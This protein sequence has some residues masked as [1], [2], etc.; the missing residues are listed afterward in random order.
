MIW[1][2]EK[3][4]D[5][6]HCEIR[7]EMTGSGYELVIGG[8]E[9]EK[10]EKVESPTALIARSQDIWAGLLKGGWRPLP[11]QGQPPL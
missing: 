1:F 7:R 3:E 9:E 10:V 4:S 11:L 6:L 5:R 2:F 8:T